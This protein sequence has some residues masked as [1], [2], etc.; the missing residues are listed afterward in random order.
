MWKLFCI[1]LAIAQVQAADNLRML[2]LGP[3]N[4]QAPVYKFTSVLRDRVNNAVL[5]RIDGAV[6][7]C[8]K[9]VQG[10][11]V[12]KTLNLEMSLV[13]QSVHIKPKAL[14]DTKLDHC[15]PLKLTPTKAITCEFSTKN[16]SYSIVITVSKI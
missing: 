3:P 16:K 14:N 13:G 10:I 15:E 12:E 8:E 11:G 1:F 2:R 6:G 4:Q 5:F 7:K 9:C